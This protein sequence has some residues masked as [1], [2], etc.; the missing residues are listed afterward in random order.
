MTGLNGNADLYLYNSESSSS[1][2]RSETLQKIDEGI[3]KN[4]TP[5]TYFIEVQSVNNA[6]TTYDLQIVGTPLPNNGAGGNPDLALDLENPL[7]GATVNDWVGDI[8]GIDYYRFTLS[9]N[10]TVDLSLTGMSDNANIELFN[11]KQERVSSSSV[12]GNGDEAIAV[13]LTSGD[14]FIEV[15]RSSGVVG[16]PYN[17]EVSATSRAEDLVGNDLETAKDIGALTTFNQT[18]WVGNFDVSDYYKF[19]VAEDSTVNLNL[20][21]MNSNGQLYLYDS[22]GEQITV[23]VNESNADEAIT[24]NLNPGTYYAG[25]LNSGNRS[26][27]T[28]VDYTFSASATG[29]PDS[30]GNTLETAEDMGDITAAKTFSNWV[31]NVDFNDYY[32]FTLTE[33]SDVNFS[34]TGMDGN[35]E[36]YLY[37]SEGE[38]ITSSTNDSNTDEAIITNLDPGTYYVGVWRYK[39]RFGSEEATS[40]NYNLTASA[41]AIADSGG[42]TLETAEDMGDITTAKTFSNWV[43]SADPDDYY[44]FTIAGD[45]TVNLNL[46]GMN[47]NGQLYLYDS[48][49]EQITS[50]TNDSNTDE[51]IAL[52]LNQGTYYTRVL[53]YKPRWSGNEATS[54]NYNLTASA[55]LL[56]DSTGSEFNTARDL[57]IV[58]TPQTISDWVG[59]L[60]YNDYYK[61]SLAQN[62]S[63][64]LKLGGLTANT[65]L[66]LYD[67]NEELIASS[68]NDDNADESIISNLTGGETYYVFVDGRSPSSGGGDTS[69]NL[70]LLPTP[71]TYSQL[72]SSVTPKLEPRIS[73]IWEQPK[74]LPILSGIST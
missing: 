48:E 20:T 18:E 51:A 44:K 11:N 27:A 3:V 7:G 17:L 70:D 22:E 32:K 43:G 50:S 73:G 15:E 40:V 2:A 65:G 24:T 49:G 42:N 52:N 38:Q 5:G 55:T 63:I 21:G 71:L 53:R 1:I 59:D 29:I 9:E 13:N 4:L 10:S 35:G 30:G 34:L 66:Y 74:P 69:Y 47:D 26:T 37:D 72:I 12:T 64:N 60:Q 41:T 57:G 67:R 28:N 45:S 16:T 19:S 25:V 54:V 61:F 31:G 68:D 62:S 23:S 33:D 58:S 46:T 39:A 56:P 14:Y 36:L 8:D 6:E